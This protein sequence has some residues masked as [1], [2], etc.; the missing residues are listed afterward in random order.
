MFYFTLSEEEKMSNYRRFRG[1]G[2][3]CRPKQQ[4]YSGRNTTQLRGAPA[5]TQSRVSQQISRVGTY[6]R[7]SFSHSAGRSIL[8]GDVRVDSRPP[9][10]PDPS[11]QVFPTE[12]GGVG[13]PETAEQ[14]A[15]PSFGRFPEETERVAASEEGGTKRST[16]AVGT[17]GEGF[18]GRGQRGE[19]QDGQE[20]QG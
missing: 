11:G 4:H 15:R 17:K 9:A 1:S 16:A 3:G 19:P 7:R 10:A 12:D 13:A 20:G 6:Q 5:E 14:T 8:W 18:V 2:A